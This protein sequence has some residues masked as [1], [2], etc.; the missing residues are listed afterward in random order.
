MFK[1]KIS[2]LMF[3]NT[4][5]IIGNLDSG[6]TTSDNSFVIFVLRGSAQQRGIV[7]GILGISTR[8]IPTC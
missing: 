2:V 6:S 5:L 3:L 4:E 1:E 7:I 8:F